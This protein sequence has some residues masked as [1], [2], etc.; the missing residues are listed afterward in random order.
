MYDIACGFYQLA[1]KQPEQIPEWLKGDF[2]PYNHPSFLE[3]YANRIRAW[4]HYQTHQYSTLL[5]FIENA[6]EQQAILFGKIELKVLA[7]MS[8]YKLKRRD[9]AIDTLSEAYNLAEPNG[10]ITLFTR[11]AKDMR[12]LTAAALRNS[13]CQIPKTWL[14]NINRKASAFEKRQTHMISAYKTANHLEKKT[15][16]TKRETE[17]LKDLSQG[18]SRTEIAASQNISVN[19]VKMTINIIYE[20]LHANNLADAIRIAAEQKI[21]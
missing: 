19:T 13:S 2:S 12:T 15:P 3:N 18:L 5:A 14:D 11:Y 17:I 16:L 1:L 6:M 8:L 4:Y 7:A 20:K 21:I 10:F 9:E